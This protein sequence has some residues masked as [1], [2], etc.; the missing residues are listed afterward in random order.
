M[1]IKNVRKNPLSTN[2]KNTIYR[3]LLIRLNKE[4]R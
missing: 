1:T 2:D 4:S 3:K